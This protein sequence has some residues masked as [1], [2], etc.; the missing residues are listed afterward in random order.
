VLREDVHKVGSNWLKHRVARDNHIINWTGAEA[1]I[2]DSEGHHRTTG[3]DKWK[4][5]SGSGNKRIVWT[6]MQGYT[7][8]RVFS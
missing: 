8:C 4:N 6:E 2:M 3:Q 1:E 7:I 5:P